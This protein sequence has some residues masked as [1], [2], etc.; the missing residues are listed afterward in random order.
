MIKPGAKIGI[1]GGG[2]LGKMTAVAASMMGYKVHVFSNE[3]NSPAAQVAT[4]TTIEK[5]SNKAALKKFAA[6][7]DVVTFEFENI[8]FESVKAIEK[9]VPV[10]P[11]SNI[12]YITQNRIREKNF[13]NKIGIP[14]TKYQQV[15]STKTLQTAYKKIGPKCIL[16]TNEMGYD[17]KGQVFI[18]ENSNLTKLWQ[19]G[20]FKDA[21][22][23]QVV[24]FKKEISV[25]IARS[26]DGGSI[27]YVPVENIHKSGILDTTI[28]PALVNQQVVDLAWER[29]HKIA[30]KLN[31]IGLLC[32]EF[33]LS[34][35]GELLVN[36]LAPRPHNSGHW[37][38]DACITS[39]FEQLIRA[40]C[41]LPLGSSSYKSSAIMK[42][43][44]GE[45]INNWEEF[46][47][48]PDTKLYIYG[49]SEARPGRK[50]GH[51]TNLLSADDVV[52]G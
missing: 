50:M 31:L 20:K 15:T 28:A 27:P 44:I 42:N 38:L 5:Y 18:D 48:D 24:D 52:V 51:I 13:L 8:P 47:K 45:E 7:V 4:K 32:V 21:I 37:T 14:T 39:Q 34:R 10:R 26:E 35:E 43:L 17:G 1:I 29:T 46:I 6:S 12:L 49:K 16:K 23:E 33:F 9:I 40:I 19:Q 25:V 3:K 11:N 36:E 22:L 2:Q 30:D 41:G